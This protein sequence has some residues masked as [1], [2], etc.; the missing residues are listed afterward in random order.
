MLLAKALAQRIRTIGRGIVEQD[1]FYIMAINLRYDR[2]DAFFQ[3][4]SYIINR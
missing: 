4:R 2:L 1:D 3:I